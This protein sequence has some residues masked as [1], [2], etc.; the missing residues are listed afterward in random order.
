MKKSRLIVFALLV[1]AAANGECETQP[2]DHRV[3]G[4]LLR[5][6]VAPDGVRY[7][8][9]AAHPEDIQK[10][11]VY[12]GQLQS[13]TPSGW[14]APDALAYWINLYN[15]ATLDLVLEKY[16]FKSIKDLGGPLSSPWKKTVATVEGRR[17]TLNQI[18]NEVIRPTFRNP[19]VHFA[20]NC[21]SRSC[22]PIRAE[23]YVG[24]R[25]AAQLEEQTKRFMGDTATNFV[26]AKG[27]L[28]LSKVF[29]WYAADFSAAEGSV[30]AFVAPYL[31]PA[32]GPGAAIRSVDY[33]WNLN[34]A[35]ASR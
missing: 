14:G 20:L 34:E 6:Y 17:L 9:W 3:Y 19:R 33:D 13:A 25:L 26:D 31:D 12:L 18:E 5:R 10:L 15:A 27:T 21:A 1:G 11:R 7:K 8:E 23:A 35:A 24:E 22:P 2:A 16:P 4:A 28:W 29:H 32:P 30:V